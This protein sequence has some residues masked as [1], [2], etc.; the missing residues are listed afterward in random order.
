M[1]QILNNPRTVDARIFFR[2]WR[3]FFIIFSFSLCGLL[4]AAT[5]M[6][7]ESPDY[8][9]YSK[10]FDL[11]RSEGLNIFTVSRFEPGFSV[12]AVFL[13]ALFSSNTI[14]YG[15]FV[16]GSML[17]KGW[18]INFYSANK[19]IFFIT[20]A[21][22]FARYFSL[23][24]LTQ[25]RAALG[26]SLTLVGAISLWQGHFY[27]GALI[28]AIALLF[29]MSV[30]AAVP[31]LFLSPSKR[32]KVILFALITFVTISIVSN[33]L[34]NYL[35]NFVLILDAYQANG[36]GDE[37]PNPFA[38]QILI[39]WGMII[40][41]LLFWDKLTLLMKRVVLLELIG[42][43]IFYGAIEFAIV[44]HRMQELYS[45]FWILF[46]AEGAQLKNMKVSMVTYG[47]VFLSIIFYSDV[48]IISGGF[49]N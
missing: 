40:F 24:E 21:F 15:W 49:F 18:A 17:L 14:V 27:R 45:V 33:F 35:A 39:D 38:L 2:K 13:G 34:L 12:F 44:A 7:G 5:Q 37:K 16:A 47:F 25:L 8:F 46:V 48:F 36:F 11:A 6:L 22:Y 4:L 3:T 10:F 32:W 28:C 9:N 30:A 19:K 41:A 31:A 29:H 1:E 23:H 20:A 26:I 43:A 42:L